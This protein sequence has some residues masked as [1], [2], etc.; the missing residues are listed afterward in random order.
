MDDQNNQEDIGW[1]CPSMTDESDELKQL[2]PIL[3]RDIIIY[4]FLLFLNIISAII[5]Y[6]FFVLLL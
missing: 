5:I 1:C 6:S 3:I 2:K 4:A